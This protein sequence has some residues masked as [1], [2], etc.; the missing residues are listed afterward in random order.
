M[1]SLKGAALIIAVFLP[2]A[3]TV[4]P[5]GAASVTYDWTLDRTCCL[6]SLGGFYFT[7][8]GTIT[9]TTGTGGDTVTAI[10]GTLNKTGPLPTQSPGWQPPERSIICCSRS[11]QRS[12]VC[13]S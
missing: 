10:T 3:A 13:Q 1:K 7:G 2:L 12:P 4:V 11:A 6:P 9:A 8:G 5:A